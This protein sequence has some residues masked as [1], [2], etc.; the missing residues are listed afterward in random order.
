VVGEKLGGDGRA[1]GATE[2][3]GGTCAAKISRPISARRDRGFRIAGTSFSCRDDDIIAEAA[4]PRFYTRDLVL[5]I[6]LR[7][8]K[9]YYEHRHKRRVIC[10]RGSM[11]LV[12]A[13]LLSSYASHI[14]NLDSHPNISP[15]SCSTRCITALWWW[16]RRPRPRLLQR[17][18]RA[19][20]DTAGS[21]ADIGDAVRVHIL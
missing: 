16:C 9:H 8:R 13:Q 12:L 2:N 14:P 11:S 7:I 17:R 18:L 21:C 15:G 3:L 10:R 1:T 4:I 6:L 19:K 5:Y 20:D